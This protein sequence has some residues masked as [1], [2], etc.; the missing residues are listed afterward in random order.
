MQRA[1]ACAAATLLASPHVG[2]AAEVPLRLATF[3]A[4]ISPPLG[5][6][7]CGGWIPPVAAQDDPLEAIGLVLCGSGEP[8]VL[9]SLDWTGLLNE[10]HAAWRQ[11]LAEAAGTTPARVAV[12]CVHQHNAPFVCLA[13]QRLCAAYPELQAAVVDPAFFSAALDRVAASLQDSLSHARPITHVASGQARVEC[14]ASNRRFLGPDGKISDWRGSS[15]QNPIHKELPEGLID[16]QL[17]T[18]AFYDGATRLAACHYYAT[19]PMSYYGDGR[20]SSDFTGL[21]RKQ[22][23]ASDGDCTHVYFTGCAGNVAAGKYND[24]TP[25]ARRELAARMHDAMVRS[26]GD[27][28]PAPIRSL[29]WQTEDVLPIARAD[30]AE[31]PLQHTLANTT[32][33]LAHRVR[34]AMM[35]SWLR[36]CVQQV[37]LTLAALHVNDATLLHLPSEMFVEY[38]LRAQDMAPRRRVATA[39]YGDGGPWYVPTRE[40]YA[41]GGYEVSVAFCAPEIDHLLTQAMGRLLA[42][43]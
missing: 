22:L 34:A 10:A 18:V 21:A 37:P 17:K 6:P 25:A 42:A 27:L 28:R 24:G 20:V 8:I 13:S 33:N 40:A 41:Q 9:C 29:S 32:E 2:S 38:Q 23:Q 16:P 5:H 7:L 19:H 43:E 35:L 39:A 36:R 11:R 31:E 12:H 14:V 15:S 1:S 3:R 4:D 26:L 30:F